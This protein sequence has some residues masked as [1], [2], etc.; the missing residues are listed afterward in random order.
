MSE[1]P[2][3][4]LLVDDDPDTH[5]MFEM[6][7]DYHHLQFA[8]VNNAEAAYA[9]LRT[10]TPDV[11]IL[12]IKLPSIDGYQA[13]RSIKQ[14]I[15]PQV[16]FIAT[17]SYYNMDTQQ[18]VLAHGFDGY[19]PKPFNPNTLIDYLKHVISQAV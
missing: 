8:V 3:T 14:Y 11:V 10:R 19:L 5:N 7:M 17:T 15:S 9:Y 2:F 12:D 18:E 1:K 4:V 16:K 13:L 6:I